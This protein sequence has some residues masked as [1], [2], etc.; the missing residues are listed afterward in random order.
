[1]YSLRLSTACG[2]HSPETRGDNESFGRR[3][4]QRNVALP[5]NEQSEKT[6]NKMAI[7]PA[8]SNAASNT[9]ESL[10]VKARAVVEGSQ[11]T[12]NGHGHENGHAN[13]HTNGYS[14]GRAASVYEQTDEQ[15]WAKADKASI[16]GGLSLTRRMA[17][18][19]RL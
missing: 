8:A 17:D 6:S 7:M 10:K 5:V 16:C 2:T 15:L 11:A 9:I 13:G 12:T 1:M 18:M 14:N 4:C 19:L 3:V